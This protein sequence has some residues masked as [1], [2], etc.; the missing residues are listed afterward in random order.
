MN[1]PVNVPVN[2]P[3]SAV[4]LRPLAAAQQPDQQAAH[5]S[6]VRKGFISITGQLVRAAEVRLT[7]GAAPHTLLQVEVTTGHGL[8]LWGQQDMGDS[9][10]AYM[11]AHSKAQ[12][13][14]AG[15]WVTVVC[16]SLYP[17]T[18]HGTASLVCQ[19]VS[20]VL[21]ERTAARQVAA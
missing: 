11:A 20:H 7:T 5:S 13:L 3:G 15:D 2:A 8:T 12:L 10:A 9:P 14:Q 1:A 18:D 21:P 19:R 6:A 4:A 16:A 17:R